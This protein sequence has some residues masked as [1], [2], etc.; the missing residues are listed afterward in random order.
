MKKAKRVARHRYP[1][2]RVSMM[3]RHKDWELASVLIFMENVES[4]ICILQSGDMRVWGDMTQA[5]SWDFA[6][7][8]FR[9][10]DN[11]FDEWFSEWMEPR[12]AIVGIEDVRRW[13]FTLDTASDRFHAMYD[14]APFRL[15]RQVE[16]AAQSL[17]SG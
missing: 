10:R 4:P 7:Y 5:I 11:E 8:G 12:Q 14:N 13:G 15:T 1:N 6:A 2:V 9:A 16:L 17:V 3:V